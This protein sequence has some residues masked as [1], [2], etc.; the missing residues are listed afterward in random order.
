MAGEI[1]LL[2]IDDDINQCKSLKN[3]LDKK[4]YQTY[5]ACSSIEALRLVKE[6]EFDLVITDLIIKGDKNGV[7]V[8]KE[9]KIL[10]PDIKSILFTGYGPEE[11]RRL[12]LEAIEAGMLDEIL[13]KPVW[14]DELIKAVE[15]HTGGNKDE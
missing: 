15:K 2:I 5:T 11:E 12:L 13:R 1:K 14:P 7:E 6:N 10:R 8:F 9:M 4:G 3:I